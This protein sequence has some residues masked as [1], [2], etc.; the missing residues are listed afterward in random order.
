MNIQNVINTLYKNDISL[1]KHI[2]NLY[3]L[4]LPVQRRII[5]LTEKLDL[6]DDNNDILFLNG[7]KLNDK[8]KILH[9][10]LKHFENN[11]CKKINNIMRED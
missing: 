11:S 7:Y 4:L 8:I 6:V 3:K 2:R 1:E 9:N 5:K 10:K